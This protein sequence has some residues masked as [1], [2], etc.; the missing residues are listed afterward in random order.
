M[1]ITTTKKDISSVE[2][3]FLNPRPCIYYALYVP[4]ELNSRKSEIY[5]CLIETGNIQ[6]FS[7]KCSYIRSQKE[8]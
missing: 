1:K 2:M 8:E 4:T 3:M 7:K 5:Q 6:T